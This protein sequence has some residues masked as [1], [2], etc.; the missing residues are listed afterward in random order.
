[1]PVLVLYYTTIGRG[2]KLSQ[3]AIILLSSQGVSQPLIVS[4]T[5][6][7]IATGSLY[8]WFSE[9]ESLYSRPPNQIYESIAKGVRSMFFLAISHRGADSA[10]VLSSMLSV[11]SGARPF[12][13]DLH[14]YSH[15]IQAIN[16]DFAH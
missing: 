4:S 12:W 14:R 9:K 10:V 1:M 5:G 3:A 13:T 8:G 11:H 16:D 15:A 7:N 6:P 2:I